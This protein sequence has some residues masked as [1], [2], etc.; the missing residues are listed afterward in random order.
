M[1]DIFGLVRPTSGEA[2]ERPAAPSWMRA[3]MTILDRP[4]ANQAE[5][6]LDGRGLNI[7]SSVGQRFRNAILF[8]GSVD[9]AGLGM[10]QVS[11]RG[12]IGRDCSGNVV[13]I[14]SPLYNPPSGGGG[15]AAGFR[16]LFGSF[17]ART[18]Y[19]IAVG[20]AIRYQGMLPTDVQPVASKPL[21][22]LDPTRGM[23]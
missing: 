20:R 8:T 15:S 9:Q 7:R 11:M 18:A 10:P 17:A 16:D 21:P 4:T 6:S 13:R 22:W 19:V 23:P 2:P 14:M 3:A 5:G 1:V 12:K